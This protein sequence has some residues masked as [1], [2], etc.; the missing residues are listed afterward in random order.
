MIYVVNVIGGVAIKISSNRAAQAFVKKYGGKIVNKVP[1][2]KK[3]LDVASSGVQKFLSRLPKGGTG[4]SQ[5][6]NRKKIK[7]LFSNIKDKVVGGGKKKKELSKEDFNAIISGSKKPPS[8]LSQ[9]MI[10]RIQEAM[11][12]KLGE[13]GKKLGVKPSVKKPGSG[14]TTKGGRSGQI[15]KG[16]SGSS[17]TKPGTS[18]RNTKSGQTGRIDWSKLKNITPGSD[19]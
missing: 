3:A 12:K 17:V 18:V 8:G 14:P 19:F 16:G 5:A 1:G 10:K 15:K 4:A 13:A 2:G 9:S 7:D 6:A 11:K